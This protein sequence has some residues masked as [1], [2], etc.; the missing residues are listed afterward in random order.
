[1]DRLWKATLVLGLLLAGVWWQEAGGIGVVLAA[2]WDGALFVA[3]L[4]AL[5]FTLFALVARSMSYV[6]ARSDHL[7]I[8]TPF[9]RLN[10][11]YRRLRSVHPAEFHQLFP[12]QKTGWA[13]RRFLEPFYGKTAVVVELDGYPM[14]PLLL[15]LFLAPQTF[16][17]QTPGYVFMVSDWMALSTEIDS[18]RGAWLES[19]KPERFGRGLY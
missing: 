9:L 8:V 6:Q 2:P 7:R 11:S 5:A 15:R 3:A 19:R 16:Y 17:P 13:S 12:P 18:L 1:M 14:P 10:T 4:V